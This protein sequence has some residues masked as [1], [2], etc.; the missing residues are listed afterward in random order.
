MVLARTYYK[1]RSMSFATIQRAA[2]AVVDP[3][4]PGPARP[5]ESDRFL[6]G[7]SPGPGRSTVSRQLQV[8]AQTGIRGS[9]RTWTQVVGSGSFSLTRRRAAA[10][11]V[12][13]SH[14]PW[15]RLSNPSSGRPRA[16]RTVMVSS[17]T[18]GRVS[19]ARPA[20]EG[21][22]YNYH[23]QGHLRLV[24]AHPSAGR[25]RRSEGFKRAMVT[26]VQSEFWPAQGHVQRPCR[27]LRTVMVSSATPGRVSSARPA[28]EGK[29]YNYH[30]Q[31]HRND[32]RGST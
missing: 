18:P 15:S 8:A 1:Q 22:N 17:A 28:G 5:S 21:K 29:N 7:G 10:V 16:L 4:H 13:A 27:D 23:H 25:R 14:E 19:R 3:P 24:L 9:A 32:R 12:K 6:A 31:W 20:G 2:A 26:F 11:G 30:H